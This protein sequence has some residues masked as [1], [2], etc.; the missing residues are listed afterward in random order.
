[1]AS[2][3]SP[4]CT[5]SAQPNIFS[6][7]TEF[8]WC[9][10]VRHALLMLPCAVKR[11]DNGPVVHDGTHQCKRSLH[12]SHPMTTKHCL[13]CAYQNGSGWSIN[14]MSYC[15]NGPDAKVPVKNKFSISRAITHACRCHNG[16]SSTAIDG[17][18][19]ENTCSL[20]RARVHQHEEPLFET[21]SLFPL[22]TASLAV[23]SIHSKRQQS[24]GT[25]SNAVSFFR[26]MIFFLRLSTPMWKNVI[27]SL[28]HVF[29]IFLAS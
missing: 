1:M 10:P 4:F 19:H 14:I 8:Y 26:S 23:I 6:W 25:T 11:L 24:T 13:H 5:P 7:R 22:S 16:P 18:T 21:Y 29:L 20:R 2:S 15:W 27:S 3:Q 28:G 9:C 12:Q 17:C